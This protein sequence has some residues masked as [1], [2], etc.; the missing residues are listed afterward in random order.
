MLRL[1]NVRK[2]FGDQEI[3]KGIDLVIENGEVVV[4]IGPSGS[5][6]T[7]LLRCL[8]FLVRAD[9]GNLWIHDRK[10]NLAAADRKTILEVRRSTAFVF[11]NYN[12]F[13]NKT[14]LDNVTLGLIKG[15]GTARGRA[16]EIA[17]AALEQVG[18]KKF[19]ARYPNTLSGG[20][21]QRVGIARAVA[22]NPD[23]ILFDEPTSALDPEMVGEVL[24][25][26]KG[27][28]GDGTTMLIV[29][30]EISF[31]REAADQVIFIDEGVVAEKGQAEEVLAHPREERTKRFLRRLLPDS[32]A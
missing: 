7:T 12:L 8:N 23:I 15:R 30:H 1:E 21:Q 6:K 28:A 26:M 31:A 13:R 32:A 3:L 18:M 16:E 9:E 14:V 10:V 25:V 2:R 24:D 22:L 17:T 11:Q 20:Q 29:T 19:M 4:I 5:G 27:L